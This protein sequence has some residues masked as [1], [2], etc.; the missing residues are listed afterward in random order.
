MTFLGS[1]LLYLVA[2]LTG[3][4]AFLHYSAIREEAE[5]RKNKFNAEYKPDETDCTVELSF[6]KAGV[7]RVSLSLGPWSGPSLTVRGHVSSCCRTGVSPHPVVSKIPHEAD[8]SD[9][10]LALWVGESF[11]WKENFISSLG[12]SKMP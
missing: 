6:T 12:M 9:F 4:L 10:R 7:D 1:V 5:K 11:G 8:Q 2:P 3:V